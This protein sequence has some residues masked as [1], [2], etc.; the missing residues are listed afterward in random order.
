MLTKKDKI[1]NIAKK[2]FAVFV[3]YLFITNVFSVDVKATGFQN[4]AGYEEGSK[5]YNKAY[6]K[7][8]NDPSNYK[9]FDKDDWDK[10][11]YDDVEWKLVTD[12]T[13]VDMNQIPKNKYQSINWD[14]VSQ[15]KIQ[16]I[17]SPSDKVAQLALV[18]SQKENR[19]QL[20]KLSAGQLKD[21]NILQ[22]VGNLGDLNPS[23]VSSALKEIYGLSGTLTVKEGVY[24]RDGYLINTIFKCDEAEKARCGIS[25]ED[26]RE[27]KN[28]LW[29]SAVGTGQDNGFVKN[30]FVIGIK[31]ED[32]NLKTVTFVGDSETYS[33]VS[34]NENGQL[35][36]TDN[37][38]NEVKVV[39]DGEIVGIKD[40]DGNIH[41]VYSEGSKVKYR[42]A[43]ITAHGD[44]T[45][46]TEIRI[47]GGNIEVNGPA[48]VTD[49][50][51]KSTVHSGK[52][53]YIFG[54]SD[55]I[56]II[57]SRGANEETI[58]TL[59]SGQKDILPRGIKVL[60]GNQQ[61]KDG[62]FTHEGDV[63]DIAGVG[64]GTVKE[65]GLYLNVQTGDS[66]VLLD[67][68]AA[69]I[70]QLLKV[71]HGL[72]SD[73]A[74][75]YE[76][77]EKEKAVDIKVVVQDSEGKT[78]LKT[79][80]CT[81]RDCIDAAYEKYYN[82]EKIQDLLEASNN[83]NL[84]S[85][86][87][88]VEGLDNIDLSEIRQNTLFVSRI[89]KSDGENVIG[90]DTGDS[91]GTG[92]FRLENDF[93]GNFEGLDSRQSFFFRTEP[94]NLAF[95]VDSYEDSPTN[96]LF[97]VEWKKVY[98]NKDTGERKV[99]YEERIFT[100][101]DGQT[102]ERLSKDSI[103]NFA[104]EI[105]FDKKTWQLEEGWEREDGHD[106]K[107]FFNKEPTEEEF[108]KGESVTNYSESSS[109][110][111]ALISAG[112]RGEL[113]QHNVD[114]GFITSD[115]QDIITGIRKERSL[116]YRG[117]AAALS[118][119]NIK[120]IVEEYSKKYSGE[121]LVEELKKIGVKEDPNNPGKYI[122]DKD[123][124]ETVNTGI[125]DY[126][127]DEDKK[128]KILTNE[129]I[130]LSSKIK[131][132]AKGSKA[133][134]Q[135]FEGI[136]Y[137]VYGDKE[138]AIKSFENALELG[139]ERVVGVQAIVDEYVGSGDFETALNSIKRYETEE[140]L[141]DFEIMKLGVLDKKAELEH[142]PEKKAQ[143]YK[144]SIAAARVSLALIQSKAIR[145]KDKLI[146]SIN[147]YITKNSAL[148][149]AAK[150]ENTN[151][152]SAQE[153]LHKND[154]EPNSD[155]GKQVI[156]TILIK[157][158]TEELAKTNKD[159]DKIISLTN[160]LARVVDGSWA[161][162]KHDT[163]YLLANGYAAS[164]DKDQA[165]QLYREAEEALGD[166]AA[167]KNYDTDS[168][169]N[170]IQFSTTTNNIALSRFNNYL[171]IGDRDTDIDSTG[172][173]ILANSYDGIGNQDN[174]VRTHMARS[175]RNLGNIEKSNDLLTDVI[176][177]YE[178][179]KDKELDDKIKDQLRS[180]ALNAYVERSVNSIIEGD[181][182]SERLDLK[183]AKSLADKE[184]TIDDLDRRI[185]Q[186]WLNDREVEEKERYE[187]AREIY[188]GLNEEGKLS[189]SEKETLVNLRSKTGSEKGAKVLSR[190]IAEEYQSAEVHDKA[191]QYYLYADDLDNAQSEARKALE[192]DPDNEYA[193]N[194]I[195]QVDYVKA[196]SLLNGGDLEGA[197][198]ILDK[199]PDVGSQKTGD[200]QKTLREILETALKNKET[201]ED[202]QDSFQKGD[203]DKAQQILD[204]NEEFKNSEQG[205]KI[206]EEID[207][208]RSKESAFKNVQELLNEGDL[209]K[210]KKILEEYPE[211][212]QTKLSGD[213]IT[214]LDY[215][216]NLEKKREYAKRFI[217]ALNNGDLEKARLV[218]DEAEINGAGISDL[219][220]GG[221]KTYGE[222]LSE[223]ERKLYSAHVLSVKDSATVEEME[224]AVLTLAQNGE[225]DQA[226]N[227]QKRVIAKRKELYE[228]AKTEAVDDY[229]E[230]ISPLFGE[231]FEEIVEE[232]DQGV[233]SARSDLERSE[234]LQESVFKLKIQ[235]AET[236][237]LEAQAQDIKERLN[238]GA[239]ISYAGFSGASANN[240]HTIT[241]QERSKLEEQL[242]QVEAALEFRR[243]RDSLSSKIALLQ[244]ERSRLSRLREESGFIDNLFKSS[245][246]R[247]VEE[248]ET[249]YK[250]LV[251]LTVEWVDDLG[252]EESKDQLNSYVS[253]ND[254]FFIQSDITK[255]EEEISKIENKIRDIEDRLG[256]P[257]G[258]FD[259]DHALNLLGYGEDPTGSEY[260]LALEERSRLLEDKKELENK[261]KTAEI[262]DDAREILRQSV[263]KKEAMLEEGCG[264]VCGRIAALKDQNSRYNP[265]LEEAVHDKDPE[266]ISLLQ[267]KKEDIVREVYTLDQMYSLGSFDS[268][269]DA[270][271]N[272]IKVSLEN[273]KLDLQNDKK[274]EANDLVSGYMEFAGDWT[275]IAQ[276]GVITSTKAIRSSVGEFYFGTETGILKE[277]KDLERTNQEIA[278]QNQIIYSLNS[279]MEKTKKDGA[280]GIT[281]EDLQKGVTRQQV[282]KALGKDSTETQIDY[283]MNQIKKAKEKGLDKGIDLASPETS[284]NNL[285][286]FQ[287]GFLDNI[288][289][290]E[291]TAKM[292]LFSAGIMA[293]T[294]FATTGL[295]ALANTAKTGAENSRYVPNLLNGISKT[296]SGVVRAIEKIGTS[297]LNPFVQT[298][299]LENVVTSSILKTSLGQ[300]L[301]R[302]ALFKTTGNIMKYYT[303]EI[304]LE[305][306]LL[307][308]AVERVGGR[309]LSEQLDA[310]ETLSGGRRARGFTTSSK[311]I[312]GGQ[313]IDYTQTTNL[314]EVRSIY[315]ARGYQIET[316][317]QG[318]FT[319]NAIKVT[320]FSGRSSLIVQKGTEFDKAQTKLENN[321]YVFGDQKTPIH[322]VQGDITL[323]EKL[324]PSEIVSPIEIETSQGNIYYGYSAGVGDDQTIY[325]SS[326][327]K[328][329]IMGQEITSISLDGAL[330]TLGRSNRVTSLNNIIAA[331]ITEQVSTNSILD[332][333]VDHQKPSLGS[334]LFN[335]D[336]SQ[337]FSAQP[338]QE[339]SRLSRHNRIQ[340]IADEITE[341]IIDSR[342]PVYTL[343]KLKEQGLVNDNY[344]LTASISL[345]NDKVISLKEEAAAKQTKKIE[346]IS[347]AQ[348]KISAVVNGIER[349]ETLSDIFS[350][351]AIKE[352]SLAEPVERVQLLYSVLHDLEKKKNEAK[353]LLEK[354][355]GSE[356]KNIIE[357]DSTEIEQEKP[358]EVPNSEPPE[359]ITLPFKLKDS[360]DTGIITTTN[361]I[362][363]LTY[364]LNLF[365]RSL[366]DL[367]D[368]TEDNV[369]E[370]LEVI[371]DQ[372]EVESSK[373]PSDSVA[374]NRLRSAKSKIDNLLSSASLSVLATDNSLTRD[375]VSDIYDAI[376]DLEND[377]TTVD[378]QSEIA[379][380]DEISGT[381]AADDY[382]YVSAASFMRD[383]N[384]LIV[385]AFA[386]TPDGK[387]ITYVARDAQADI[388][389]RVYLHE[390]LHNIIKELN[391]QYGAGIKNSDV[392][393][394]LVDLLIGRIKDG[395]LPSDIKG[396]S[397]L[398]EF[399]RAV[400]GIISL[401]KD[402]GSDKAD[403][404]QSLFDALRGKASSD[405]G[406]I[407]SLAS[408]AFNIPVS[409]E[410][411]VV[412]NKDTGEVIQS[413]IIS[414]GQS[415][416]DVQSQLRQEYEG[417]ENTVVETALDNRISPFVE[418]VNF[419]ETFTYQGDDGLTHK[420]RLEDENGEP[421][422]SNFLKGLR[423]INSKDKEAVKF[424]EISGSNLQGKN[425][426]GSITLNIG[427]IT[428]SL[429]PESNPS[430]F[431]KLMDG[432]EI[433]FGRGT[434]S[435]MIISAQTPRYG[436]LSRDHFMLRL[437]GG[438]LYL[439]DISSRGTYVGDKKAD[440]Y[441]V[442]REGSDISLISFEDGVSVSLDV[443]RSESGIGVKMSGDSI[444]FA[445][446][447][448]G[449]TRYA[450]RFLLRDGGLWIYPDKDTLEGLE[451][452]DSGS[453][454]V[455]MERIN[456]GYPLY[457]EIVDRV[458]SYLGTGFFLKGRNAIM[459]TDK[460][461]KDIISE[462]EAASDIDDLINKIARLSG[463]IS[464]ISSI[465]AVQKI[466]NIKENGGNLDTLPIKYNIR[467]LVVS[468]LEKE[469]NIKISDNTYTPA[470]ELSSR[471][472]KERQYEESFSTRVDNGK[473]IVVKA[474]GSEILKYSYDIVRRLLVLEAEDSQKIMGNDEEK[475][476]MRYISSAIR[477]DVRSLLYQDGVSYK[478]ADILV[479]PIS[480][481]ILD[482]GFLGASYLREFLDSGDYSDRL[483]EAGLI[484]SDEELTKIVRIINSGLGTFSLQI[485]S[486]A[487]KLYNLAQKSLKEGNLKEAEQY[488]RQA[489]EIIDASGHDTLLKRSVLELLTRI[490]QQNE[491]DPKLSDSEK[492]FN[493]MM[494]DAEKL[495]NEADDETFSLSERVKSANK[496]FNAYLTA[497]KF[498]ENNGLGAEYIDS[499]H[500]RYQKNYRRWQELSNQEL[501]LLQ[502][503][504]RLPNTFHSLAPFGLG[505]VAL[506]SSI[507]GLTPVSLVFSGAA[508]VSAGY[509]FFDS[510][511]NT[512]S[513]SI[514]DDIPALDKISGSGEIITF[515]DK[516][517]KGSCAG[518]NVDG[519][520]GCEIIQLDDGA[521][522][523]SFNN[524]GK[525]Y[526]LVLD[527]GER[528]WMSYEKEFLEDESILFDDLMKLREDEIKNRIKHLLVFDHVSI[529]N[530]RTDIKIKKDEDIDGFQVVIDIFDYNGKRLNEK[531]PDSFSFY[532]LSK[533]GKVFF[534]NSFIFLNVQGKGIGSVIMNKLIDF[535]SK[536]GSDIMII[537]SQDDGRSYWAREEFGFKFTQDTYERVRA[538]YLKWCE[539]NGEDYQD[540]GN[541]P[542]EYPIA[543]LLETK[544]DMK[545]EKDLFG[546]EQRLLSV[547]TYKD[548]I[549]KA[550]SEGRI[551]YSSSTKEEGFYDPFSVIQGTKR[552]GSTY[553]GLSGSNTR[554]LPKEVRLL[555]E[556]I[557]R[558]KDESSM[559]DL[560]AGSGV[561]VA[562][563]SR[564]EETIGGKVKIDTVSL[565][566]IAT[567]IRLNAYGSKILR[568]IIDFIHKNPDEELEGLDEYIESLK[569]P[570]TESQKKFN[571]N[572]VD[573]LEYSISSGKLGSIPLKLLF[574]LKSKGYDVLETTDKP[575]ISHQYIGRFSDS[576][577]VFDTRYDFVYDNFGAFFYTMKDNPSK[578]NLDK[579]LGL[580]SNE[581]I[582]Y[583]RSFDRYSL[584]NVGELPSGFLFLATP[585]QLIVIHKLSN[586]AKKIERILSEHKPSS[587]GIYKLE[588]LEGIIFALNTEEKSSLDKDFA[589]NKE[590]ITSIFQNLNI[591]IEDLAAETL[592]EKSP[593]IL[594]LGAEETGARLREIV[595]NILNEKE[596][597]TKQSDS[598]TQLLDKLDPG[599]D[600]G[601][602]TRVKNQEGSSDSRLL[603]LVKD[604]EIFEDQKQLSDDVSFS[605]VPLLLGEKK[606][607]DLDNSILQKIATYVSTKTDNKDSSLDEQRRILGLSEDILSDIELEKIYSLKLDIN[608][609]T[610]SGVSES[611]KIEEIIDSI[612]SIMVDDS[613]R[614]EDNIRAG[615]VLKQSRLAIA[616]LKQ[617]K[618]LSEVDKGFYEFADKLRVPGLI[619]NEKLELIRQKLLYD[620]I[621]EN[622]SV[623][624]YQQLYDSVNYHTS[625][626]FE[627]DKNYPLIIN[628]EDMQ[629]LNNMEILEVE[630]FQIVKYGED[631]YVYDG[632]DL[633]KINPITVEEAAENSRNSEI[634][635]LEEAWSAT[636]SEWAA[637]ELASQYE[638][639]NNF[640]KARSIL[641]QYRQENRLTLSFEENQEILD[642]IKRLNDKIDVYE[643]GSTGIYEQITTSTSFISGFRNSV[644]NFV[645]RHRWAF[646][647]GVGIGVVGLPLLS[648]AVGTITDSLA[649]DDLINP[650]D[651]ETPSYDEA[652]RAVVDNM[653]ITERET[654]PEEE[655]PSFIQ[656]FFSWFSPKAEASEL[657]ASI[658]PTLVKESAIK[659]GDEGTSRITL[660]SPRS[661]SE[662]TL[663]SSTGTVVDGTFIK[664]P[665]GFS[666]IADED[667]A[668]KILYGGTVEVG[669][670]PA[671]VKKEMPGWFKIAGVIDDKGNYNPGYGH[672]KDKKQEFIKMF[673]EVL[674]KTEEGG[675][676]KIE[677]QDSD[678]IFTLYDKAGKVVY[679]E[680]NMDRKAAEALM[681]KNVDGTDLVKK[682]LE[683]KSRLAKLKDKG[684]KLI[685]WLKDEAKNF[686]VSEA[687]AGETEN[688]QENKEEATLTETDRP[689]NMEE[690]EEYF[691][692][693]EERLIDKG[694]V[695]DETASVDSADT[696]VQTG[697][698][699]SSEPNLEQT[700]ETGFIGTL[701]AEAGEYAIEVL[702][703]SE[704]I[705]AETKYPEERDLTLKVKEQHNLL[706]EE[707]FPPFLTRFIRLATT[708]VESGLDPK[709]D[710]GVAEGLKQMRIVA[711]MDSVAYLGLLAEEGLIEYDG[712][713]SITR[714]QA[715]KILEYQM[716]EDHLGN[717]YYSNIYFMKLWDNTR[718]DKKSE[719][720]KKDFYAGYYVGRAAYEEGN[721][722]EAIK[723]LLAAYNGG[724]TRIRNEPENE[725]P[726][727]SV[728]YY[729]RI[730]RLAEDIEFIEKTVLDNRIIVEDWKKV[731]LAL[732]LEATLDQSK[733]RFTKRVDAVKGYIW[734]LR[735]F[736]DNGIT[737][738]NLILR[739]A[740]R[741]IASMTRD[742]SIARYISTL[743]SLK[744]NLK[745]KVRATDSQL[746]VL[747]AYKMQENY[748]NIFTK[749]VN[750]Q[751]N[752]DDRFNRFWGY[753]S[754]G[755]WNKV[756]SAS[757]IEKILESIKV[758]Q[759]EIDTIGY[760]REFIEM[761]DQTE[762]ESENMLAG[763]DPKEKT[764]LE[765]V[766]PRSSFM[767]KIYKEL[768]NKITTL[769]DGIFKS[770]KN[771]KRYTI[772]DARFLDSIDVDYG[773]DSYFVIEP[774]VLQ[775]KPIVEEQVSNLDSADRTNLDNGLMYLLRQTYP[776]IEVVE[777][778]GSDSPMSVVPPQRDGGRWQLQ[779][780]KAKVQ[781]ILSLFSNY[782]EKLLALKILLSHEFSEIQTRITLTEPESY[783]YNLNQIII[784]N[785][786]L[787]REEAEQVYDNK[788]LANAHAVS[789][790]VEQEYGFANEEITSVY[791]T[792]IDYSEIL[793]KQQIS[794]EETREKPTRTTIYE[795]RSPE[796][797]KR[798]SIKGSSFIWT[799]E[800]EHLMKKQREAFSV[801]S[802]KLGIDYLVVM[803]L[804]GYEGVS[805]NYN[806]LSGE[807]LGKLDAILEKEAVDNKA[808]VI[809][810]LK[811]FFQLVQDLKEEGLILTSIN[812]S[813]SYNSVVYPDALLPDFS[814][815]VYDTNTKKY[816][817][818]KKSMNPERYLNLI[819]N[820][821][822]YSYK[823]IDSVD[824]LYTGPRKLSSE[825]KRVSE[826]REL[827]LE[828][829]DSAKREILSNLI[830]KQVSDFLG[831][832]IIAPQTHTRN[833]NGYEII[834]SEKVQDSGSL[835]YSKDY[836]DGLNKDSKK[837][838]IFTFLQMITLLI[839]DSD[840]HL[841]NLLLNAD[842][843][844]VSIDHER[845]L[846]GLYGID[847][848]RKD[849]FEVSR[850]YGVLIDNDFLGSV[851]SAIKKLNL[852][853]LA[854]EAGYSGEK[855]NLVLRYLESQRK[856]LEKGWNVVQKLK[857]E[858]LTQI[859]SEL[860]QYDDFSPQMRNI[861]ISEIIEISEGSSKA[862]LEKP[863]KEFINPEPR[864][865]S[866][867][868]LDL[869][870]DPNEALKQAEIEYQHA[871]EK[872][873]FDAS[874]LGKINNDIG[875][876][877]ATCIMLEPNGYKRLS[878]ET[879]EYE[880]YSELEKVLN[881]LS[882][883]NLFGHK[884]SG[885]IVI[886]NN[887]KKF[888]SI[889][890]DAVSEYNKD[891]PD[892]KLTM[893]P[894]FLRA[895][896][897]GVTL[898]IKGLIKDQGRFLKILEA[899]LDSEKDHFLSDAPYEVKND[900]E[901]TGFKAVI[902]EGKGAIE[903]FNM[904]SLGFGGYQVK[905]E[906]KTVGSKH[907]TSII[908]TKD[909]IELLK[910]GKI[911]NIYLDYTRQGLDIDTPKKDGET[912]REKYLK[913]TQ[914][915][916]GLIKKGDIDSAKKK[917]PNLEDIVNEISF[918]TDSNHV[919]G[920]PMP[921]IALRDLLEGRPLSSGGEEN[922][923]LYKKDG[924]DHV[925]FSDVDSFSVL[926]RALNFILADKVLRG[927]YSLDDIVVGSRADKLMMEMQDISQNILDEEGTVNV[928]VINKIRKSIA[929]HSTYI[930]DYISQEIKGKDEENIEEI[931]RMLEGMSTV[932][933]SY[934]MY[935]SADDTISGQEADPNVRKLMISQTFGKMKAR[936]GEIKE[937]SRDIYNEMVIS[938]A[939]NNGKNGVAVLNKLES[940]EDG[941][942]I[943][944]EVILYNDEY[945]GG[946]TYDV[947][948]NPTDGTAKLLGPAET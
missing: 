179:T 885:N 867:T 642:R 493:F 233:L 364:D 595:N 636:R 342:N 109:D 860:L 503:E 570:F 40:A 339:M 324:Y 190:E 906:E 436:E 14:I 728:K 900:G 719:Q 933:R 442:I 618:D 663:L 209:E 319:T 376:T 683:K 373:L 614:A 413:R 847:S 358:L 647:V 878:Q 811:K 293:L 313:V 708:G 946:M 22:I 392:E 302:L 834:F 717:L 829:M 271:K 763:N 882:Y 627:D 645:R 34:I 872:R 194:V 266:R 147:D 82:E 138:E 653:G 536:V 828:L 121:R 100:K 252:L 459:D 338:Y 650:Q 886:E 550:E 261:I 331:E 913:I 782:N 308:K 841:Y 613:T 575:F 932:S 156:Q 631:F 669:V 680:N 709:A 305:E 76:A 813:E 582:F 108:T 925:V 466:R 88:N 318:R 446:D 856:N 751:N 635:V 540:L 944:G 385:G 449:G 477:G 142:D 525:T 236:E 340:D 336:F 258:S 116:V 855:L 604:P 424:S 180:Q 547:Q 633:I 488:L 99:V 698:Q 404:L 360:E 97:E 914:D 832:D 801:L 825:D 670:W 469:D 805:K 62:L 85:L 81:T 601:D 496:A 792:I 892:N 420:E 666:F 444:I 616:L 173:Q 135:L 890:Q 800:E 452:S 475:D 165:E 515:T 923:I 905:D 219:N 227:L 747:A 355:T 494:S 921:N 105:P 279:L 447:L 652:H 384:G 110:M 523:L 714:A 281:W 127:K 35:V 282:K 902:G 438:D 96:N 152:R 868:N 948:F 260:F 57:D 777:V 170:F 333:M 362:S 21:K 915:I 690:F 546:K 217:E 519:C 380:S 538:E 253:N 799:V 1:W 136:E 822:E 559:I 351:E 557:I 485:E 311:V 551:T 479:D 37:E 702:T 897:R 421:V 918:I 638:Y 255:K 39:K 721:T 458:N 237:V 797:K 283:Y 873:A 68:R 389:E 637:Y 408:S 370:Q 98:V 634:K 226:L 58:V 3:I 239:E 532:I 767:R 337:Y 257:R 876:L 774:L 788:I 315:E 606:A 597:A 526:V 924:L 418:Y 429:S 393:E 102:H 809:S 314:D 407:F 7:Y 61:F 54:E 67:S 646:A 187:K 661:S 280:Y 770:E 794:Y 843:K 533:E 520:T 350:E 50:N 748:G 927:E 275:N 43:E 928:D 713:K 947:Q 761:K 172:D 706:M 269:S 619:I 528:K 45:S 936:S 501:D 348:E 119:G 148:E 15:D 736:K 656:P 160:E 129:P 137:S 134:S 199:N 90:Y 402:T 60:D 78:E 208:A 464:G 104:K 732:E 125:I 249:R 267:N 206:Q 564:I 723:R 744:K 716:K 534:D 517:C 612:S 309:Y 234:Q 128:N 181:R 778:S 939:K 495:S 487:S 816:Y 294:R 598:L 594:E 184:D 366:E 545:Y 361:D 201:I 425:K 286:Y 935:N 69:V 580:L 929:K 457:V 6:E 840:A 793:A 838:R 742:D 535:S 578:E 433:I 63:F 746:V 118:S 573:L 397:A 884:E 112:A 830:I 212:A 863:D 398:L 83:R 739:K 508:A 65:G 783:N 877:G 84:Q 883:A 374:A 810:Q 169:F 42:N 715:E 86:L 824:P 904:A 632:K 567:N 107:F 383:D 56:Q 851:L 842:G 942:E 468:L 623:E 648:A 95:Y 178:S 334:I 295:S 306:G 157:A 583:A 684:S 771:V 693:E 818:V 474:V 848:F 701:L 498:A 703:G 738:T 626:L 760:L 677:L 836:F 74:D 378:A 205:K 724:Y 819:F 140:D 765:E 898:F 47:V 945:P 23:S 662:Y 406:D 630:D 185:A 514:L 29:I 696:E 403:N 248:Q 671:N 51:L 13:N 478:A 522:A 352:I 400:Q 347:A 163:L 155:I 558:S 665:F 264:D 766:S 552:D 903:S 553:G 685:S 875:N 182:A 675:S 285:D 274:R 814:I 917:I 480:N 123:F 71:K 131:E 390:L 930:I 608:R 175:N 431:T 298:Q 555:V 222:L 790:I 375:V 862:P 411:V 874:T 692:M 643:T 789:Q 114:V 455:R 263:V 881:E 225:Y 548:D 382:N 889:V 301:S 117:I 435:D 831:L 215:V 363:S 103:L 73:K 901:I 70:S 414:S 288:L 911:K 926:N 621:K 908:N 320:D 587:N 820:S 610:S 722:L 415:S 454:A 316:V 357:E 197:K 48:V 489:Q 322:E 154:I 167:Q 25:L 250:T 802:E 462:L 812:P 807:G 869:A 808:K 584:E 369:A 588:S 106:A 651:S 639:E 513:K 710:S 674:K 335:T 518:M 866:I 511:R 615:E 153:Y 111:D 44:K 189:L 224:E 762:H 149:F 667:G 30:G 367:E 323:V 395:K 346:D 481:I 259:N 354:Y 31:G 568:Y 624:L 712:P 704:A 232:T 276:I 144:E 711:I 707:K 92:F 292:A 919:T 543:F 203:Y 796:E 740:A 52:S 38:G 752:D 151:L 77:L 238:L 9:T 749:Y 330:Q 198:E 150:P 310:L 775:I 600:V 854:V 448:A 332:N 221:Q 168:G 726:S 416:S 743:V 541:N 10:V 312:Y 87:S 417:D 229:R 379:V 912:L 66:R 341:I 176:D 143:F 850:R 186:S 399:D 846:S 46:K 59:P 93:Y 759:E 823:D 287:T 356:E 256:I 755:K 220:I 463:S 428:Y 451:E 521:Y 158:L 516:D 554:P 804:G 192:L 401:Q 145:D 133:Y 284:Y 492:E 146:E 737:P 593:D 504:R 423:M 773:S 499:A 657:H 779:V 922:F 207:D 55:D 193:K 265:L 20:K 426:V 681:I 815:E 566:P 461:S 303:F 909:L 2:C 473:I 244:I 691:Q 326:E 879:G 542:S 572:I 676:F 695:D 289:N 644:G 422:E 11:N 419:Y 297:K 218:M 880:E 484:I 660:Y 471:P 235:N 445:L 668:E 679:Q 12:Y 241:A 579:M 858:E 833:L 894:D 700:S 299:K 482:K 388:K 943:T 240:I 386:T 577:M 576:D 94:D 899:K 344:D 166:E 427:G 609:I 49:G 202:I 377:D 497:R 483:S 391:T 699:A 177:S 785:P 439:R 592:I 343:E 243:T 768:K 122:V 697:E 500:Q 537:E 891:N 371:G 32:G 505:S 174:Y 806:P 434:N 486:Q 649:G 896:P 159:T 460:N 934:A 507:V 753:D 465:D 733:D 687:F 769:K 113:K 467:Y 490:R 509:Y 26:F 654:S 440:S 325:L 75:K 870:S 563:V 730:L 589:A 529:D 196:V 72:S 345:L 791:E 569:R 844:I 798:P 79:I 895:G 91:A 246:Q 213:K 931:R 410:R 195:N 607:S 888:K 941:L 368:F 328:P 365:A 506:A 727:E 718:L 200:G 735:A 64:K 16:S 750:S 412:R 300:S 524:F 387:R 611:S 655:K 120:L 686:F 887:I 130:T 938:I 756:L 845:A 210:A 216:N 409:Q 251:A 784:D 745:G 786:S 161:K 678:G 920:A 277:I 183:E 664:L 835:S 531:F 602:L 502:R 273:M 694:V 772:N 539:N 574:S 470:R 396:Q 17:K 41:F 937:V 139:I 321:A 453:G 916:E 18:L 837:A 605:L 36:Y 731:K 658:D 124:K 725:W 394:N 864:K 562:D 859:P 456:E 231:N 80:T 204:G 596:L 590:K 586:N 254:V 565:S 527:G 19:A 53:I 214:L 115:L 242:I 278:D 530:S 861:L 849:L 512:L 640:E 191:A 491:I 188:E 359:I 581:G 734:A 821:E 620:A 827:A 688:L 443:R 307:P 33:G 826:N 764:P 228:K 230:S 349:P 450:G 476:V 247:K 262:N 304:G 329:T 430:A 628:E 561:S 585:N 757:S 291:N 673:A 803:V 24:F 817:F 556:K 27:N 871:D 754:K 893:H 591:E 353:N 641:E 839:A 853:D 907:T 622:P 372:L 4:T 910:D 787:S 776:D 705:A 28:L 5:D 317:E 780:D 571:F 672:L 245:D 223:K 162:P 865:D 132:A 659:S 141:A 758:S 405:N 852:R 720:L 617:I 795:T 510:I 729:Q 290:I 437:E 781:E 268:L 101:Q 89:E 560:G 270:E 164:G 211:L 544:F 625:F 126:I 171:S 599:L 381:V 327:G 272:K 549:K 741:H 629:S 940:S 296:S 603:Q 8:L 857:L 682:V 689:E 472:A 432:E 441:T